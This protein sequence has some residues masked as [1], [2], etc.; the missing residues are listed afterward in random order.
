MTPPL[1][2]MAPERGRPMSSE[3]GAGVTS[4]VGGDVFDGF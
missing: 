3:K 4:T 2:A 1:K